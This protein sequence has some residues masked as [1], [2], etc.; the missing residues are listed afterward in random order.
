MSDMYPTLDELSRGDKQFAD[1]LASYSHMASVVQSHCVEEWGWD[2]EYV[3]E[4][5]DSGVAQLFMQLGAVALRTHTA[6]AQRELLKL[7]QISVG[8][9]NSG[10]AS[11]DAITRGHQ[12]QNSWWVDPSTPH[13]AVCWT[14][15]CGDCDHKLMITVG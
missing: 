6:S 13:E 11:T 12:H 3:N 5:I 2:E 14:A 10:N 4:Y 8:D 1:N 9:G 7:I 15:N